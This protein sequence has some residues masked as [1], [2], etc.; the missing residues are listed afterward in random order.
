MLIIGHSYVSRLKTALIND[1][2]LQPNF[3]LQQCVVNCYGIRGG[4][5]GGL[6]HDVAL[7]TYITQYQPNIILLQ[8]G[9]NDLCI[10]CLRPE[11]LACDIVDYMNSLFDFESVK[12]V[13]VWELFARSNTRSVTPVI[14][15]NRRLIVNQM[16]PVLIDAENKTLF[17]WKHLRLM[18]S[19]LQIF[20]RDGIH[21][22]RIGTKKYYRSLRLAI[23]HALEELE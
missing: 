17:F 18:N 21:L 11:T 13:L 3:N 1:Q 20:D 5:L 14:Y 15:E 8:I 7:Q 19:P 9:G 10:R 4:K 22:S 6:Q 2:L 23:L 16:L 12:K